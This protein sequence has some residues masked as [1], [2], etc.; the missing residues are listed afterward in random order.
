VAVHR[1]EIANSDATGGIFD[2]E[3]T[4]IKVVI[5][6]EPGDA[7]NDK[8]EPHGMSYYTYQY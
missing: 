3:V 7:D 4:G 2:V 5:R 8:S 1:G 6:S